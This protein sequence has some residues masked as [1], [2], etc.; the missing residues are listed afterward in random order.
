MAAVDTDIIV[1]TP[2]VGVDLADLKKAIDKVSK[3]NT[4]YVNTT[5]FLS[6]MK[7]A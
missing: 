4:E 5:C 2:A 6:P 1:H 3:L 7:M